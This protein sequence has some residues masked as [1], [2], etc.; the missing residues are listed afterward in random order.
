MLN[1]YRSDRPGIDL[2]LH[3]WIFP[4]HN[5]GINVVCRDLLNQQWIL[6]LCTALCSSCFFA[7]RKRWCW[8]HSRAALLLNYCLRHNLSV[9]GMTFWVISDLMQPGPYR[10]PQLNSQNQL[11]TILHHNLYPFGL[12]DKKSENPQNNRREIHPQQSDHVGM[13]VYYIP[14]HK[15]THDIT[16]SA[17]KKKKKQTVK[18]CIKSVNTNFFLVL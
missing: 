3:R 15:K 7:V 1:G 8:P 6:N 17:S 14:I 5:K 16:F 4:F 13:K 10:P 12:Y 11:K 18:S 9:S 2:H